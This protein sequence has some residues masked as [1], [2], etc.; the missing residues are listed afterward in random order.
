MMAGSARDLSERNAIFEGRDPAM[1]GSERRE[2][3]RVGSG[4]LLANDQLRLDAAS[5]DF[6]V[7]CDLVEV[8]REVGGRQPKRL[9]QTIPIEGEG[10]V[11]CGRL[12]LRKG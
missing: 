12:R 2:Q 9:G 10:I 7:C 3:D 5:T 4:G 8:L 6:E 11:M 1:G